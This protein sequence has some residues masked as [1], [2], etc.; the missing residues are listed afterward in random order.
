MAEAPAA[1]PPAPERRKGE[2]GG[3]L[4]ALVGEGQV[5]AHQAGGGGGAS[6]AVL[7]P[8]PVPAAEAE[9]KGGGGGGTP[10]PAAAAGAGS[11]AGL[12]RLRLAEL[13]ADLLAHA[14]EAQLKAERLAE[15]EKRLLAWIEQVTEA[16]LGH[17]DG[18][19]LKALRSGEV[20]VRY[21]YLLLL[22]L[23]LQLAE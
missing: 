5:A 6:I 10:P 17:H 21:G 8:L 7:F 11:G 1:P 3:G 23:L 20:L 9:A 12:P 16:G 13:H 18:D 2:D 15:E 4:R 22:L 14:E 19:L